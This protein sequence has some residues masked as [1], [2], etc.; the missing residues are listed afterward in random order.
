M[1]TVQ[2]GEKVILFNVLHVPD[3]D[4]NL[5]SIDKVLQWDYDVLFSRDGCTINQG[6]ENIIEAF[7]VGNLFRVNGKAR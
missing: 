6:N 1:G 5:L 4:I 7:R 3:L 2:F